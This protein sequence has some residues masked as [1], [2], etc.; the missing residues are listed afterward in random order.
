MSLVSLLFDIMCDNMC[1][2]LCNTE[3]FIRLVLLKNG[4]TNKKT[5]KSYGT[6]KRT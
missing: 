4:K 3:K 2:G 1:T 6:E 5:I